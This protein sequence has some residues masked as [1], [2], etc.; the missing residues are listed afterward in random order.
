MDIY[1]YPL[2]CISYYG[3]EGEIYASVPAAVRPAGVQQGQAAN[4]AGLAQEEQRL[5][6]WSSLK[7]QQAVIQPRSFFSFFCSQL[8]QHYFSLA[9]KDPT[10]TQAQDIHLLFG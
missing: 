8:P 9:S 4:D 3:K 1:D 10:A 5:R 7:T 6:K 2:A